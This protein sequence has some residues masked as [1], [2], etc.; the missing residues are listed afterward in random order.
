MTVSYKTSCPARGNVHIMAS[1]LTPRLV[2]RG[3]DEALEFYQRVFEARLDERYVDDSGHVVHA[4]FSIGDA[5]VALTEERRD[6]N[7]D[8]PSS[9][10]GSPVILNFVVDDVD[11]L[12][13]R[14]QA[15]GAEMIF[16]IADQPYGH[17]EGRFRDPFGHLWIITTIREQLTPD[18]IRERMGLAARVDVDRVRRAGRKP[19]PRAP[20][21]A[22]STSP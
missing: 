18:Q 14:L 2:V 17:R 10:G 6:W 9:L 1:N 16:P 20:H 5:V 7:N 12:G 19:A 3:A 21:R 22:R 11:A 13:Q 4:A 8:S 15:A